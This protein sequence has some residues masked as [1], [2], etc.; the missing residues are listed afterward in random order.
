MNRPLRIVYLGSPPF[1]VPMLEAL[2]ASEHEVV[3]VITAPDKPAGRGRQLRATAVKQYAEQAGLPLL[4]PPNLK[5]PGFQDALRAWKADLQV[6]VAFRMLPEA[7]WAMPPLGTVNLHASLLPA[8][9]GAA[10]IHWAVMNGETETGLSTFRLR[11]AIDTGDLMLQERLPIG[12]DETTGDVMR[13]MMPLGAALVRRTVD[14]IAAGNAPSVPQ[15]LEGTYPAA[16]KLGPENTRVD[17]TRPAAAVHHHIRGLNPFPSA[18]TELPTGERWKL[19]ASARVP[20]PEG[21]GLPAEAEAGHLL[22]RGER[23]FVRCADAWLELTRLQP[24]GKKPM[25]AGEFLRGWR[26]GA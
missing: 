2:H 3:G 23:L 21:N 10:P 6:V 4:Q 17:W 7:V 18:W 1:A 20:D 22:P 16:P 24:A 14:A 19:H 13:R 5:D 8:Y 11:H 12:P 25:A 9:R 15:D 26:G